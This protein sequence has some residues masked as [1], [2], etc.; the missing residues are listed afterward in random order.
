MVREGKERYRDL[1]YILGGRSSHKKPDG[2]DLDG[3]REKWKP[4]VATVR[5]TIKFAGK[6]GRLNPQTLSSSP[7]T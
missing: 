6:T 4:N 1:S 7:I 3:P 5:A 2:S